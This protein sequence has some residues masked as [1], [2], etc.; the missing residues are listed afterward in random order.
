MSDPYRQ[1]NSDGMINS[2][3]A[4]LEKVKAELSASK[5]KI[6]ELEQSLDNERAAI[7]NGWEYKLVYIPHR[8]V[9][10]E[11]EQGSSDRS[12]SLVGM[13]TI[14]QQPWMR[15]RKVSG[16]ILEY[17]NLVLKTL[18]IYGKQG[19]EMFHQ[20]Q[21]TQEVYWFRRKIKVQ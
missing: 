5:Q 7:N 2:L 14:E 19:W 13:L 9:N 21:V 11:S 12:I 3:S 6:V 4:E 10:E 17:Q 1:H 8:F 20:D 15:G 18:E 16:Y